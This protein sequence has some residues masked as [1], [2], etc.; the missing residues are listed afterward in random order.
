M[1][2]DCTPFLASECPAMKALQ[3]CIELRDQEDVFIRK[4][5]SFFPVVY[6]ASPL[7]QD[8]KVAGIVVCF[9][10]DS[11]RKVLMQTLEERIAERTQQLE[12]ATEK[13]RELSVRLMQT[14]DEERRRI[15]RELHDGVGQLLA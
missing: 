1:H 4:D 15:A 7:S 12:R 3:Q 9:R 11:K 10:D 5:G 13:L 2:P 8:G 6:S 14:Q